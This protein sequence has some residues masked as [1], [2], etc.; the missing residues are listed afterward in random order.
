MERIRRIHQPQKKLTKT[1]RHRRPRGQ[2][3]IRARCPTGDATSCRS[4]GGGCQALRATLWVTKPSRTTPSFIAVLCLALPSH[5]RAL[6]K[7]RSMASWASATTSRRPPSNQSKSCKSR[8]RQSR[9]ITLWTANPRGSRIP[10]FA[11]AGAVVRICAGKEKRRRRSNNT[12]N[13]W[14]SLS[15]SLCLCLC[16]CLFLSLSLSLSTSVWCLCVLCVLW[17]VCGVLCGV[18]CVVWHRENPVCPLKTCPC[19]SSK[20]PRVYRYHACPVHILELVEVFLWRMLGPIRPSSNDLPLPSRQEG[21]FSLPTSWT[22]PLQVFLERNITSWAVTV[23]LS[24]DVTTR[25]KTTRTSLLV[26]WRPT[27]T[28]CMPHWWVTVLA[29]V[30]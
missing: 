26:R 21:R 29:G 6:T 28:P 25:T 2:M 11:N 10:A 19:V 22:N 4:S 9:A 7:V 27:R 1:C 18:V 8:S 20:R 23:H 12:R 15:V 5:P 14:A 3:G 16:L 30:L 13:V 17:C 24:R